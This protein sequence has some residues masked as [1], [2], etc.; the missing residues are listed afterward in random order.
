MEQGTYYKHTFT[1][2]NAMNATT[3]NTIRINVNNIGKL[4]EA[5]AVAEGRAKA[6]CITADDIHSMINK[7]EATL[8]KPMYKKD[9]AGLEFSVDPHAQSFPG[10]YKGTPESTQF[11]M[12]R[13]A[14]GWFVTSIRRYTCQGPTSRIYCRNMPEKAEAL[15]KFAKENW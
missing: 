9:W 10:A 6:R 8:I 3:K 11:T 4:N 1:G 14:S 7:I 15:V 5:I 2:D 12:L 13:T